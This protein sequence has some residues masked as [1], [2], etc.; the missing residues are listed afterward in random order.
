MTRPIRWICNLLRALFHLPQFSQQTDQAPLQ[1]AHTRLDKTRKRRSPLPEQPSLFSFEIVS[2]TPAGRASTDH[3]QEN[4]KRTA[5]ISLVKT[6]TQK[7]LSETSSITLPAS[8]ITL[9]SDEQLHHYLSRV[10]GAAMD[11]TIQ[12]CGGS[13]EEASRRL[14]TLSSQEDENHSEVPESTIELP[15]A[16]TRPRLSIAAAPLPRS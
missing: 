5:P 1:P 14:G 3:A 2:L 4:T 16:D 11:A 7:P 12:A 6:T 13:K 9:R 8:V 15:A 10:A